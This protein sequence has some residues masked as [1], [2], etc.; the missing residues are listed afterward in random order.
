MKQF[1][2]FITGS[3]MIATI[4]CKNNKN[5]AAKTNGDN[6]STQPS[7]T[8]PSNSGSGSSQTVPVA[9]DASKI[10]S[11]TVPASYRVAVSFISIGEGTDPNARPKLD[12]YVQ[13]FMDATSKRIVF[14]AHPWGR[15]GENDICFTLDNLSPEEQVRFINGVKEVFKGNDLV[16]VLENKKNTYRR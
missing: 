2:L 7:S 15:E 4:A 13:Q 16:H 3:L 10:E 8:V 12:N 11:D 1:K 9:I 6:A 5:T 14:A